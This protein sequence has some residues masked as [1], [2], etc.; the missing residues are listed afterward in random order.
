MNKKTMKKTSIVRCSLYARISV[1][2]EDRKEF[3][4]CEVQ[5]SQCTRVIDANKAEHWLLTL[6]LEDVGISGATTARPGFQRLLQA[7][8]S[9]EIDVIVV[10]NTDRIS[11]NATDFLNFLELLKKHGVRLVSVTQTLDFRG[12]IGEFNTIVQA[13]VQ[14]LERKRTAERTADTMMEHAREG[15]FNGGHPP[16]GYDAV[17]KALVVVNKEETVA[18]RIFTAAACGVSL[19]EI[20]D[21]LNCDGLRTKI[22]F[23]KVRGCKTKVQRGGLKFRTDHLALIIRNPVYK[24][25]LRWRGEVYQGRHTAI[26]DPQLWER[27]N[28][29]IAKDP[30]TPIPIARSQDRYHHLLKGVVYCGECGVSLIPH[31]SGKKDPTGR[32]F[33][34][35]EC[36]RHYREGRKSSRCAGRL[37]VEQVD[38]VVL[39]ALA[40]LGQRPELVQATLAAARTGGKGEGLRLRR[41]LRELDARL[42]ET[43]AQIATLIATISGGKLRSLGDALQA[44]ADTLAQRKQGLQRERELLAQQA[45]RLRGVN[46]EPSAITEALRNFEGLVLRLPPPKRKELVQQLV[47]RI[48]INAEAGRASEASGVRDFSVRLWCRLPSLDLSTSLQAPKES[49]LRIRIGFRL[50]RKGKG[51]A[52]MLAAPFSPEIPQ[53]KTITD[54]HR[55]RHAIH[56]AV[57]WQRL[58]KAEPNLRPADIAR[59]EG[60]SRAHVSYRLQLLALAPAIKSSLLELRDA[61]TIRLLGRMRLLRLATLPGEEQL[62]EWEALLKL[63]ARRRKCRGSSPLP[64]SSSNKSAA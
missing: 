27:A 31:W 62:R 46:P 49:R 7:V 37:P 57:R 29:A 26:I 40:Q 44:E 14:Q 43:D 24:G 45:A 17:N 54:D 53:T 5:R 25:C 22:R 8:T 33:R 39:S 34:Y 3:T 9:R 64:S 19:Q 52:A 56:D 23:C 32:P 51:M 36:L 61:R 10:Y 48:E 13:A 50:Q 35:Y 30:G 20:A 28:R 55:P 11:R 6:P 60:C 42:K 1:D 4:S 2:D 18:R 63:A 12:A 47:E 21:S 59:R 15:M 41:D 58:L 16:L 38:G